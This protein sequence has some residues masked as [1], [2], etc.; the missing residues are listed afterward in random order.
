[1]ADKSRVENEPEE[2]S[3]IQLLVVKQAE[4]AL[5]PKVQLQVIDTTI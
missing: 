2:Y 3:K 1:M 5:V 4:P